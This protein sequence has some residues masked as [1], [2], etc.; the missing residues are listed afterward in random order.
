MGHTCARSG[1]HKTV[2]LGR[3]QALG[4]RGEK[5]LGRRSESFGDDAIEAGREAR[6]QRAHECIG[7]GVV[8]FGAGILGARIR[9]G[10]ARIDLAL[11]GVG[12]GGIAVVRGG[13]VSG[14]RYRPV[15][16]APIA[17]D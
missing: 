9:G 10:L 6:V 7:I 11:G 4:Q 1:Q 12:V 16:V 17:G 5:R 8:R 3:G 15:D 14:R 13:R 2:K